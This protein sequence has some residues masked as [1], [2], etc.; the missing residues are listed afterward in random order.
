MS[1]ETLK[2][3]AIAAGVRGVKSAAQMAVAC[4]GGT[5]VSV[6]YLDWPQILG[7]SATAFVLSVLT[8]VAG[9]PEVGEGASPLKGA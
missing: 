5:A 4:I 7:M 3:W 2:R 6:I 9:V 8:S 1:T